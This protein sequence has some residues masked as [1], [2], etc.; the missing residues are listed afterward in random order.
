MN[1]SDSKRGVDPLLGLLA[2]GFIL[3][4]VYRVTP[5]AS[6]WLQS[7]YAANQVMLTLFGILV[8][9]L[10]AALLFSKTRN[11]IIDWLED[12]ATLEP[13]EN[14][15]FLGHE[16]KT[17]KKIYLRDE[18]R[19]MHT[20]VIGTTNA[21][22]TGSVILPWAVQDMQD[23]KGLII[24]DGK[25]DSDFLKK[26]YS[27]AIQ[28]G[29]AQ[30]FMVLS[31][32]NPYISSTYNPFS[33]GTPEL[34]AER[35]FASL[36]MTEEYYKSIQFIAFKLVIALIQR[37]GEVPMP[38]LVK[39]LL[40]DKKALASWA[41]G[42]T[43]E[44]LIA[45]LEKII[46]KS[47]DDFKKDFS[48]IVTALEYFSSGVN[49]MLF[50]TRNSE[51]DISDVIRRQKICY[52]QLPTMQFPF[53]GEVT[54]KLL[55]QSIQSV[56]SEIQTGQKKP[57]HM[58]SI[59]L[60]DFNDYIYSGFASLLNKSRS[61]NIGVVFSHQSLG[62]LEKVGPDF[63]QIVLTNTNVKIVMR[64]NDPDSAEHFAKTFGTKTVELTTERQSKGLWGTKK[65]GEQSV[66]YA[67]EFLFHPNVFKRELG[68]GEA[69]ISIPHKSRTILKRVKFKTVE[70]IDPISM[71]IRDLPKLDLLKLVKLDSSSKPKPSIMEKQK[72]T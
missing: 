49:A 10:F 32:A 36:Q 20:Q 3:F 1:K 61:G 6:D 17:G 43:D 29:R 34:I 66:R 54:G 69:V 14:S 25:A 27:Y 31:L 24:I 70:D 57:K 12:D 55:L 39:L 26:L 59:Y 58:F 44:G 2:G 67:E 5:R 16:Y 40:S 72:N 47:E 41:N 28:A 64:S 19:L 42:L 45:Q 33:K 11:W 46:E 30:D 13:D 4:I 22:K 51:I 37:R 38:G 63:K 18:F 53:L 21:G 68:L 50:N 62:D 71:P 9:L 52:V 15:V 7:Y 65:T 56:V 60:D 23:G 8:V 35:F 48:G